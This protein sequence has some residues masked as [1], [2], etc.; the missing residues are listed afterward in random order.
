M[1]EIWSIT[2]NLPAISTTETSLAI[3]AIVVSADGSEKA[4]SKILRIVE[5]G[6]PRV[7]ITAPLEGSHATVGQE[8]KI[9][10]EA[11]DDTLAL[12]T[13]VELL[14]DGVLIG[15]K[16]YKNTDTSVD[17]FFS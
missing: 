5:N 8:L 13:S 17:A 10:V 12:G 3:G 2:P 16:Q 9:N 15:T 11:I 14:L 6:A 4:P 7:R 1:F